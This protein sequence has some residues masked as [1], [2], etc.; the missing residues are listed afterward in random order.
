[1]IITLGAL[2]MKLTAAEA[3]SAVTVNAACAVNRGGKLGQILP[4]RQADMV[5]WQM[6]DYRELPYHYGINLAGTVVKRGKVVAKN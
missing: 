2:Q 6:E 3:L 4:G 5:V 1:M